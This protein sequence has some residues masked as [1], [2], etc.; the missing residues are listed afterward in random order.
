M[1]KANLTPEQQAFRKTHFRLAGRMFYPKLLT[2]EFNKDKGKDQFSLLF[3]WPMNDK[4]QAAEMA[5]ISA[6]LL[7]GKNTFFKTIPVENLQL[8]IKTWGKYKKK[9]GSANAAFLQDCHWMNLSANVDFRPLV[10]D[11]NKRDVIDK[12]ELYSGRNCAIDFSFWEYSNKNFGISTNISAVVLLDGGEKVATGGIDVDAA[13]AGFL[14]DSGVSTSSE[15]LGS[16][17][18]LI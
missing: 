5:K 15:D 16:A 17:E 2:P 4:R 18:S 6:H 8:P 7:A 11:R 10:I 14:D 3:A 13:F 1:A 9:D 12:A